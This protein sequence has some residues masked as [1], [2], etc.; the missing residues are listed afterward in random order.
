MQSCPDGSYKFILN[1]QDHFTKFCIL[2][3]LK[4]KTAAEVAY[5]LLDIFT[6]FGASEILQ[7]DNGREFV[8]KVIQELTMM[9]KDVKIV[10]GRARHPQSQSSVERS[11]QDVKLLIGIVNQNEIYCLCAIF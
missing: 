4:T 7:S 5:H 9:W 3:P 10:H 1:Y 6:M 2:K 8:V 11:N